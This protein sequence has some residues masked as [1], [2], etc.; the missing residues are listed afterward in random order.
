MDEVIEDTEELLEVEKTL[1][2]E[3]DTSLS[4]ILKSTLHSCLIIP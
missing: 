4:Q 2:L 3:E 1:V